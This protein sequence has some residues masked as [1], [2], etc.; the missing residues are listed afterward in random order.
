MATKSAKKTESTTTTTETR[1]SHNSGWFATTA[2]SYVAV[3]IGGLALFLSFILQKLGVSLTFLPVLVKIAN[4]IA[5][6]I[7]AWLSFLYIKSKRKTWMWVV[8][9]IAIVMI[10]VGIIF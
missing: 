2:F 1:R 8:W 5:W 9:A 4:S 6:A 7:V 3:C 10:I